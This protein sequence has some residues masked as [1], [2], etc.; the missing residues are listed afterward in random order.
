VFCFGA[1]PSRGVR[2]ASHLAVLIRGIEFATQRIQEVVMGTLNI[3]LL[4]GA[5]LFLVLYLVR[6]RGRLREED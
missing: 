1:A 6:R 3:A 2:P 4:A 5:G